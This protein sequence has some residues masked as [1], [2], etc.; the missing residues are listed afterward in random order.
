MTRPRPGTGLA[1]ALWVCAALSGACRKEFAAEL[2]EKKQLVERDFAAAQNTWSGTQTGDRLHMGDG[3]RTGSQS[4]A[5]LALPGSGKLL[6]RSDTIVRFVRSLDQAAPPEQ[7]EVLQG[8]LTVET[9]TGEL[10][11][12]TA[13]GVVRV[14]RDSSIRVSADAQKLQFDVRIG[15]VDYSVDGALKS[16]NAGSSFELS[17]LPVS[18]ERDS[19]PPTAAA[20]VARPEAA[21]AAVSR[22][23]DAGRVAAQAEPPSAREVSDALQEPPPSAVLT[24]S[25]GES[26]TIH[27]PAP[28]S[29]VRV[30]FA[31][32][33][34]PAVLELDRGSRRFDALRVRA[35][36]DGE[37]RARVP[38]G[39]YRYRVRC[40]GS[41][42]GSGQLTVLSDAATRPLPLAPV[43]ITADADGRRYS[44]SYQNRLPTVTLRWPYAPPSETYK[45]FVQPAA[46]EP[47]QVD[48]RQTSVTLPPGRLGEGAHRFW[49]ETAAHKRS[50]TGM[51]QV[52]FDYAARTAYLTS[53]REREALQ[54]GPARFAGGTLLGSSVHL[55]GAPLKLDAHGRFA[56]SATLSSDAPG[57][58]VRVMHPSTG[59]HYYVRHLT[60]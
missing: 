1:L 12:K 41:A 34:E 4:E 20:A 33:R 5:V 18:V 48:A 17:V 28:P 22:T 39:S 24:F 23:P 55:Q 21:A 15:R 38:R 57:A 40:A 27:D 35:T 60:P 47:F 7:L 42:S 29:D 45:L 49:F 31:T 2:L 11:V 14:Q 54:G 50:E 36:A 58:A 32:C 25:A 53:P 51:L 10:G 56:G 9:G 16:A 3:L 30:S 6:V 19:P 52:S 26:V 37:L 43:T 44:V 59:I 13:R 46:A 8:E